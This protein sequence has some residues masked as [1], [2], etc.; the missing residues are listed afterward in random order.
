M[1]IVAQE[2]IFIMIVLTCLSYNSNTTVILELASV[3]YS[4]SLFGIFLVLAMG[5]DFFF[6]NLN[7]V[8]FMLCHELL[9]LIYTCV[10]ISFL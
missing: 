4:F 8:I 5:S 3:D 10:L 9:G 6:L 1:F 2:N 7:L